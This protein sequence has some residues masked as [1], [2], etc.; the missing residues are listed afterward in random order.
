[1]M[2]LLPM[3]AFAATSEINRYTSTVTLSTNTVEADNESRVKVTINALDSS[4]AGTSG[5]V[6]LAMSRTASQKVYYADDQTSVVEAVYE[7][8]YEITIPSTGKKELWIQS[9]IAGEVKLAVGKSVPTSATSDDNVYQYLMG[10]TTATADAVGLIGTVQTVTFTGSSVDGIYV[11]SA[12]DQDD[13]AVAVTGSVY[14][15]VTANGIDYFKVT[16]QAKTKGGAPVANETMEISANKTGITFNK[17]SATTDALGKAEFKAYATKS[18]DYTVEAKVGS[19]K[20]TITL[21]FNAGKPLDIQLMDGGN[22]EKTANDAAYEFEVKLMD[23]A[24]NK[25]SVADATYTATTMKSQLGVDFDVVTKPTDSSIDKSGFAGTRDADGNGYLKVTIPASHIKKE[26]QYLV[27]VYLDNGKSVDVAFESRKQGDIVALTL[28]YDQ[29]S[30]A[31]GSKTGAPTVKRVDAQ[32]VKKTVANNDSALVWSVSDLRKVNPS[33]E[34]NAVDGVVYATTDK[35]Y[36]GELI[37][38]VVDTS[39]KKTATA[40]INIGVQ[41]IGIEVATKE[42]PVGETTA[43]DLVVKDANGNQVAFGDGYTFEKTYTIISKPEGSIVSVEDGT[44]MDNNLKEKGLAQ[45]KV[46]GNK[47]GDAQISVVIKAVKSGENDKYFSTVANIK[48]AQ[49]A[50]PKVVIGAKNV[51]MFIG[52]TGYVQDSA[53]KVMD[54]APF[55]KDGRTFVAVRPLAEAFGAEIGWNEAT[56]TVTLT[57]S[58]MTL[59]IVIGSNAITKVA[60]G[61]TST[62]TADVPAFIKDGRTVLPFRAVGEAFGATV[63]YDATTQ[64]VSFA[65]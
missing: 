8:V 46:T 26:G 60:G 30:L 38:T 65:Q 63:S 47:A 41:P 45:I 11:A 59:T 17:T 56:Q 14:S 29:T 61:V 52:A 10:K 1:M 53:A 40:K 35:D 24:G 43:L 9:G 37:V 20:K 16:F 33:Y 64:A 49:P 42:I 15:G 19:E 36:A 12:V 18:G 22:G 27:R 32:G 48:I 39:E 57:R 13:S 50:P 7:N 5:T 2:T 58:D 54:V 44:L 25:F 6:Y 62:V 51:T 4:Y 28:E 34:I 23:V 3:A 31:L 55:I 21:S